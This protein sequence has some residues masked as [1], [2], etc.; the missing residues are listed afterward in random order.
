MLEENAANIVL[1]NIQ[2]IN[3][4]KL[5]KK[6]SIERLKDEKLDYNTIREIRNDIICD[7]RCIKLSTDNINSIFKSCTPEELVTLITDVY[8]LGVGKIKQKTI[9]KNIK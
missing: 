6:S 9:E 8:D 2:K 7:S 5:D 3:S 1:K 4:C